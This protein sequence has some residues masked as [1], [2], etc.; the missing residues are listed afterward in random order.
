[1]AA[2]S[3]DNQ[4]KWFVKLSET[5]G[6]EAANKYAEILSQIPLHVEQVMSK[7]PM[8]MNTP[9]MPNVDL[10]FESLVNGPATTL[11]N[12]LGKKEHLPND[13][14]FS[15]GGKVATLS[16]RNGSDHTS[17][18][19]INDLMNVHQN[20]LLQAKNVLQKPQQQSVPLYQR[21]ATGSS[22]FNVQSNSMQMPLAALGGDISD[23]SLFENLFNHNGGLNQSHTTNDLLGNAQHFQGLP[24]LQSFVNPV[25]TLSNSVHMTQ[26]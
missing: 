17:I 23:H 3:K 13:A 2:E 11:N 1:M 5:Q 14:P 24:P 4:F 8:A 26:K 18:A 20:E 12:L 21:Q 19:S 9:P 6:L 15:M 22:T 16:N 25:K 10:M 7:P